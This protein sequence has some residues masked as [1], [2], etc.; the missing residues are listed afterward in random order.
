MSW[1]QQVAKLRGWFG[2]RERAAELDDE[3]R[4]HLEMEERE[5]RESGMTLDEAHYAALRRFGNVTL[6]EERSRDMW[7]WHS[8]ETFAHDV[9]YA[10]RQLR[11]SPGFT[12]L[13][14]LTL[15]LGI[16]ANTAIFS[17]IN[18]VFLRP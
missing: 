12:L 10:L 5:N 11:R 8:I 17:V 1:K 4:V 7:T 13:A 16:G 2:R 9:R 3:I 18:G 6:A 15:A 14:V